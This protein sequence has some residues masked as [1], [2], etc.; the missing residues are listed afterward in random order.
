M[1]EC[2]EKDTK[3]NNEWAIWKAKQHLQTV[4][5]SKR[6]T[7][8]SNNETNTMTAVNENNNNERQR[9]WSGAQLF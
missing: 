5:E 1:P 9:C 6:D 8:E 3:P 7:T 2:P 4:H